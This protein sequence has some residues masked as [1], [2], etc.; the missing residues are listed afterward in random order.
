MIAL[1][2]ADEHPKAGPD[3]GVGLYRDITEWAA[4]TPGWMRELGELFT[5]GGI[6]LFVALLLLGYRRGDAGLLRV[7]CTSSVLAPR[8]YERLR[9]GSTAPEVRTVL[10]DHE[11]SDPPSESRPEPDGAECRYYRASGAL[12]VRVDVYRL[13]FVAGGLRDKH[14]I[15]AESRAPVDRD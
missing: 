15:T 7:L 4:G 9:L 10:P 2:L 6:L 3:Y 1:K 5:E 13:C 12:F 8:R 14:V 11:M